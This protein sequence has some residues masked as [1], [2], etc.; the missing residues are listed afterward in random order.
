MSWSP[1]HPSARPSLYTH[2]RSA[3][4]DRGPAGMENPTVDG[5]AKVKMGLQEVADG[6]VWVAVACLHVVYPAWG[7]GW[8]PWMLYC[9]WDRAHGLQF[10]LRTLSDYI[11]R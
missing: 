2:D 9:C 1:P 3:E 8:R 5:G 7:G 11:I 6:L 10:V 4:P